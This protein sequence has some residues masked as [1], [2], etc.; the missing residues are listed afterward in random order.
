MGHNRSDK[1]L[2]KAFI[3]MIC[4]R[5]T[6][7]R[8]T[9]ITSTGD[10]YP[11]PAAR[12]MSRHTI[13]ACSLVD[14]TTIMPIRI[15]AYDYA[16]FR[17][18]LKQPDQI[19]WIQ[20]G[21]KSSLTIKPKQLVCAFS[22]SRDYGH[23]EPKGGLDRRMLAL[24]VKKQLNKSPLKH[25]GYLIWV[26]S[27][28]DPVLLEDFYGLASSHKARLRVVV[29]GEQTPDAKQV[30]NHADVKIHYVKNA[31]E[32]NRCFRRLA[33]EDVSRERNVKNKHE[34]NRDMKKLFSDQSNLE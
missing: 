4:R 34:N 23:W 32:L 1:S 11:L 29:Y 17:Q 26:T 30:F 27:A 16:R 14:C 13:V 3:G 15:A 12:G 9:K 33:A 31:S 28:L 8:I 25:R 7:E 2:F 19:T 10:W 18:K 22:I 20:A 24:L 21:T 5:L 6:Y